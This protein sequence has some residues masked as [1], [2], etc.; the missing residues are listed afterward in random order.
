MKRARDI[1]P[2][3]RPVTMKA[4]SA[5]G[6]VD[7][8]VIFGYDFYLVGHKGIADETVAALEPGDRRPS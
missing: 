2:G 5:E 1:F 8:T 4:G 7:D 3:L 6:V